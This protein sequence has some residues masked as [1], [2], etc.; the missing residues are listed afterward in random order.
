MI[1]PKASES[2]GDNRHEGGSKTS[3]DCRE[4][5]K[6]DPAGWESDKV[7]APYQQTAKQQHETKHQN[8]QPQHSECGGVRTKDASKKIRTFQIFQDL[9]DDV[10]GC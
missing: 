4:E 8:D 1:I 9:F 10:D 6:A 7:Q 3:T 5:Q 2:S